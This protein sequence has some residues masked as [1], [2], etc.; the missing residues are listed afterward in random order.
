MDHAVHKVKLLCDNG[1][2][3]LKSPADGRNDH[4]LQGINSTVDSSRR[5]VCNIRKEL[6]SS[7]S[8]RAQVA[9]FCLQIALGIRDTSNKKRKQC[10]QQFSWTRCKTFQGWPCLTASA[11][12]RKG[13]VTKPTLKAKMKEPRYSLV[14]VIDA[15]KCI[16]VII[17]RLY[18][19]VQKSVVP[20]FEWMRQ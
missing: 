7:H 16:S 17:G 14:N 10:N 12:P 1:D 3:H 19:H 5:A 8:M 4:G 15:P 6:E 2:A 20:V 9:F 13:W 11:N 18:K